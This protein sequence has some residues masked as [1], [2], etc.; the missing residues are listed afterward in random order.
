MKV[1]LIDD[2][3]NFFKFTSVWLTSIGTALTAIFM[4]WPDA[5][6][7]AWLFLPDELKAALPVWTP[8]ALAVSVIIAGI[9]SRLFKQPKLRKSNESNSEDVTS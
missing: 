7:Q 2:K 1:E 4:A 5:A 6:T 8:K 3:H 9:F